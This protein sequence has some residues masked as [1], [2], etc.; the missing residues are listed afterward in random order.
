MLTVEDHHLIGLIYDAAL[1]NQLWTQVIQRIVELSHSNS[2]IITALDKLNPAYTLVFTHN[3]PEAA[4]QAY[5]SEGLDAID[6]EVHG[7]IMIK[8]GIGKPV[9]V[10]TGRYQ[11]EEYLHTQERFFYDKCLKISNIGHMAGTLLEYSQ[12]RWSVIGI[13]R[14]ESYAAFSHED[15]VLLT[16]FHKHIRRSL[17]IH[18]QLTSVKQQNAQLYRLL[19]QMTVGVILLNTQ[20]QVR[21]ANPHAEKLLCKHGALSLDIYNKLKTTA[22]QQSKLNQIIQSAMFQGLHLTVAETGG[23]ISLL[24]EQGNLPLVLTITPLSSVTGYSELVSDHVAVAIFLTNAAGMY[25]LSHQAVEELYGLSRREAKICEV[26]IN[27]P[28]LEQTAEACGLTLATVRTYMKNIYEKTQQHS[29][30]ELLRLL[31]GLTVGFEHI[32]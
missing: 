10:N 32:H 31:I 7:K 18:R 4:L 6:M 13:H 25:V 20:Q 3:L 19:D 26:F 17:Q 29:Q 9:Q 27:H 14:P 12:Y 21:Y 1:D 8:E 30:A 16:H 23:V 28:T 11:Q 22:K 15:L 24:D 5:Q 2:A